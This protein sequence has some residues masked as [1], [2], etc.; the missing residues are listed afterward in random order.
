MNNI[1]PYFTVFLFGLIVGSFLNVCI[2]RIP[3]EF[4]IT[5]PS[6]RCPSCNTPI[7]PWDNIP[8]VSYLLLGGKCR[9]CKTR[10]SFRYP[11]VEF[12]NGVFYVAVVWKF[13]TGWHTLIYFALSSSLIVIT[14]IDLD[15]QIIPDRIT[16]PGI[17]IGLASSLMSMSKWFPN[18]IFL[19]DPFLRSSSLGIKNSF[20]GMVTGFGLFYLVALSG[21]ALFKKE[22]LG[23]GD[24]K[25]MAMVGALTG[26]KGVLST[27]FFGS[28]TGTIVGIFLI[29]LK[30]KKKETK[31]PF[32]PFLAFGAV[33]TIF[34][35]QEILSW[36]IS[37]SRRH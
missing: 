35:G 36:Y 34:F 30:G 14:F 22:A 26:W 25:M 29:L 19:I 12:L 2:Y 20:I 11:F 8:I 32:G 27:T 31:I 24:I 13:G 28:L 23:G 21:S 10:I 18:T 17:P 5:M 4:S 33:I 3:R 15:F 7:K 9:S 1:I 6:S 16:I 37:V